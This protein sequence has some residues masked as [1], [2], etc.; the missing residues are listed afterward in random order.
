LV[1]FP[2]PL[3]V[4]VLRASTTNASPLCL[5]LQRED[6]T[7]TQ[8]LI[9]GCFGKK[10]APEL[11]NCL[12]IVRKLDLSHLSLSS[13]GY[14]DEILAGLAHNAQLSSS[15]RSLALT[16]VLWSP[17]LTSALCTLLEAGVRGLQ[18]DHVRISEECLRRLCEC[19]KQCPSDHLRQL[20]ITNAHLSDV[21]ARLIAQVLQVS[22]SL[23]YLR[24]D[25]NEI[26]AEGTRA[27]ADAIRN[28]P[29]SALR[30]LSLSGNPIRNG[31]EGGV[32]DCGFQALFSMLAQNRTLRDLRLEVLSQGVWWIQKYLDSFE[33]ALES[34][35]ALMTL[36]ANCPRFLNRHTLETLVERL[37]K[38]RD[39]AAEDCQVDLDQMKRIVSSFLDP[40]LVGIVMDYLNSGQDLAW[41]FGIPWHT[42]IAPALFRNE[43]F[44]ETLHDRAYAN[45]R[46]IP[47]ARFPFRYRDVFGEF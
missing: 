11:A 34:N 6:V 2:L 46:Q 20:E 12:K 19:V 37:Q 43:T 32:D 38:N 23:R 27:I 42:D 4:L 29:E 14:C 35:C 5:F 1:P 28:N 9:D 26:G 10:G 8:L 30:L 36:I 31:K 33:K 21:S 24:L 17:E 45:Q 15:L 25:R 16:S 44:T 47:D 3:R 22:S 40:V 41:R 18:M 13:T 39:A 7:I